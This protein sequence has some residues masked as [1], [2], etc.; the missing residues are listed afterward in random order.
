MIGQFQVQAVNFIVSGQLSKVDLASLRGGQTALIQPVQNF[1]MAVQGLV[2]PRA[3][4]LAR[5]ASRLPPGEREDAGA[6]FRR[7]TRMLALA[8]AGLAVL[9]VAV[10]WPLATFVLVRIPKFAHIAPLALPMSIQSAL[11]LVQLPFTAAL[12]AM[13]RAR[14][15]FVQYI[16]FTTASLTGLVVGAHLDRLPGAAWGLT[17]GA[18]V[19]L[20][21]MVGLYRYALRWLGDDEP[22]RFED[23]SAEVVPAADD[24]VPV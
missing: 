4:R 14:M 9:L 16:V 2:I 23:A 12:R 5:D 19:G 6:Q 8:F 15:L 7:Q 21:L 1:L 24:A 11:Y 18:A 10:L 20:A 17:A 3:S 13:H 22:D